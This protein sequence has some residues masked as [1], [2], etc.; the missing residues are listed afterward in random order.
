[1][2]T[3]V[4]IV[5]PA[6]VGDMVM[7][8]SLVRVL[9]KSSDAI[10]VHLLAPPATAPLGARMP[11]VAAT[12]VLD[13]SH[14]ELGLAKR[15]AWGR[16]HGAKF[17]RAIVL[18]NSFKSALAPWWARIPERT[19]WRGEFRIGVLTD[20]RVLDPV[21]Y[22]RMVER[23][24]ALGYPPGATTVEV[25]LPELVPDLHRAQQLCAELGL[26]MT[27]NVVVLCPGA[28]FGPAKRWPAEHFAAVARH[29]L[30][31]GQSVWIM[32]SA[33]DAPVAAEIVGQVPGA[34][35]DLCGRTSLLDAVDLLSLA[36]RVVCNDSGLMHVAC[37]LGKSVVAV[38]GST[39]P[40]FTP[41]LGGDARVIRQK[42]PCSPCFQRECPLG[43]LRCL[44]DLAPE[45][46][47]EVL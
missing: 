29:A 28:E 37:A 31:R 5:A 44:R 12:H 11:G 45:K 35:F 17:D 19:G 7:A 22:P 18:P 34:V 27:R 10:K 47:I 38:F 4:L 23:F 42:L 41:P 43:H 39:S 3:N 26:P 15:R 40:D 16:A 33:A 21:A 9:A 2:A 6:W 25:P 24:A 13:T 32:G 1:M 8:H 46:V 14:G 20:R 30:E 36:Q